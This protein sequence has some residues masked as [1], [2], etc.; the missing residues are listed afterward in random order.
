MPPYQVLTFDCYGT[1]I[2][3]ERGMQDALASLIKKKGLSLSAAQ[4]HRR[5]AEIEPQI[6]EGSDRKYREVMR[7]GVEGAFR[8]FEVSVT[9]QEA[10]VFGETLASWPKFPDTTKVLTEL[11]ARGHKLVILSNTDE[12]FI[13]ESVKVIGVEFDE[14]ITAER[15]GSYKP[16]RGHWDRML[17]MLQVP[18]DRVLH[19]AQS[20][21]HDVVPAK[22]LG[23]TMAWINR[24]SEMPSGAARPDYEFPDLRGVL[25]II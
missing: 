8:E 16:A 4:V 18:K 11:K 21:Y 12:D 22:G 3:W 20:Y 6:Q 19:V 5:Y 24:K 7:L 1:L 13:R 25:A 23:F 9:S 17:D 15:V 2:D 14:I 10:D